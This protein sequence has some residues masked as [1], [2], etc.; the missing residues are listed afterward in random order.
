MTA[1]TARSLAALALVTACAPPA[2]AQNP[3]LPQPNNPFRAQPQLPRPVQVQPNV[4]LQPQANPN[5]VQLPGRNFAFQHG[6]Q[7]NALF[8]PYASAVPPLVF[9]PYGPFGPPF[10]LN[11]PFLANPFAFGPGGAFGGGGIG[12]VPSA[13][14]VPPVAVRQPGGFQFRAPNLYVNPYSGT[15]YA[16]LSGVA[17]TGDGSLFF[18]VP[19][20]GAANAF[21]NYAP[22]SGLYY[23]F[24]SGAYLNPASGVIARPGNVFLP[25]IY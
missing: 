20:T 12:F 13:A 25:Y 10:A 2:A 18:R 1:R 21:G 7:N 22:G 4:F 11:T 9:N 3:F 8:G 23:N 19:G 14:F 5:G 16:P 6:N 17:Q 24:E 15:A